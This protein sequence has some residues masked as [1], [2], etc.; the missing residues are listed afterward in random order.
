MTMGL[1]K[2][3]VVSLLSRV[4]IPD[5]TGLMRIARKEVL[6]GWMVENTAGMKDQKM[7]VGPPSGSCLTV[8][9]TNGLGMAW[10]KVM[11]ITFIGMSVVLRVGVTVMLIV[12]GIARGGRGGNAAA[13]FFLELTAAPTVSTAPALEVEL[14]TAVVRDVEALKSQ[15]L[16]RRPCQAQ[17]TW[18]MEPWTLT[19]GTSELKRDAKDLAE[20]S[21]SLADKCG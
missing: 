21:G 15:L 16:R 20:S 7:P 12:V 4:M 9:R 17:G 13:P 10:S 18:W 5:L 2:D 14:R 8:A 19:R 6:T 3:F 11:K 1:M